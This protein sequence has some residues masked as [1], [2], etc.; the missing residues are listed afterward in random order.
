MSAFGF[1]WFAALARES[2]KTLTYIFEKNCLNQ[3]RIIEQIK[4]LMSK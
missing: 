4:L 1:G 2:S 3:I